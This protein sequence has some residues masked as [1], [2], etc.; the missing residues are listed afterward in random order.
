GTEANLVVFTSWRDDEY[1]GDTN[2]DGPSAGSPG[3]WYGLHILP[4]AQADLTYSKVRY[5][6]SGQFGH[7]DATSFNNYAQITVR[8]G[9]LSLRHAE[10]AY[11]LKAGI[12]LFGA[13]TQAQIESSR[14]ISNTG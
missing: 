6:G 3:E 14:I 9:H 5:A 10:V 7:W 8:D 12:A 13:G 4:D 2:G 1:G 11:G